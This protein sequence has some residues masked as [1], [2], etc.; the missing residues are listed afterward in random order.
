MKHRSMLE[1]NI[2]KSYSVVLGTCTDLLKFKPKQ[3]KGWSGSCT[4][5]YAV[6][7][8]KIIKYIIFK[9]EDQKNLSLLIH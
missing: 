3:R 9:L 6:E 4:K 2:Q 1:E 7:L 8:I 5:F